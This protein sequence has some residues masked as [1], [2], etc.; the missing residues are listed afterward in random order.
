MFVPFLLLCMGFTYFYKQ[1]VSEPTPQ[2]PN[3]GVA[4]EHS[5]S[6][7]TYALYVGS[8]NEIHQQESKLQQPNAKPTVAVSMTP[9][10]ISIPTIRLRENIVPVGLDKVGKM[11][12]PDGTT[13]D[14]GWYKDGITPGDVGAA[15]L[16]AHVY[17]AFAQ[18]RYVKMGDSIYI[19]TASGKK[20]RFVVV[21]SRVYTLQELTADMLFVQ[22]DHPELKLITCAGKL[23]PDK[24]T[25][26]KRLILTAVLAD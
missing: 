11:D 8:Q 15:V 24:T 22:P 25:Y 3:T 1:P 14:V 7:A 12:V 10:K 18:L 5:E 13:Q 19:E 9:K 4:A 16:D 23:T 6:L 21:D 2:L 26:E 20:V 17:A